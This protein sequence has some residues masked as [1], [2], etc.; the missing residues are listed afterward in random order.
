M[1]AL[2]LMSGTSL[3]GVDVALIE[4]DGEAVAS[5]GCFV[6]VPY[7][8]EVRRLVRATFGAEQGNANTASAERAVTDA[9][10]AAVRE[11][12]RASWISIA[13]I[14]VVGFHGQTITH[15]PEKRFTW[16]L[17]DGG[18]LA[19]TLGVRVVS[20]LRTADVVAGGQ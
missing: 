19:Q 18:A 20:D 2:G 14:D 17:G 13:G 16:Q 3:D 12:S 15:R 1:R 5:V 6:T 7:G 10:A 11:W 4:T 8:D 9:H